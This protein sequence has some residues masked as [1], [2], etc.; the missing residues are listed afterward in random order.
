MD[1]RGVTTG[2]VLLGKWLKCWSKE[3]R[4]PV[5]SACRELVAG[6]WWFVSRSVRKHPIDYVGL[7]RASGLF[8]LRIH[9]RKLSPVYY[10]EDDDNTDII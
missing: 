7:L 2:V 5:A 9:L 1:S 8:Y 3:Y 10:Y 6:R 4:F